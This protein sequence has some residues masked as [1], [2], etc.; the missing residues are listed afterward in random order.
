[1]QIDVDILI[2]Q[3]YPIITQIQSIYQFPVRKIRFHNFT[4]LLSLLAYYVA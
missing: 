4:Y 3:L 2:I 1:M